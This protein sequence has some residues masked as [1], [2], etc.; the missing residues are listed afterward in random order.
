MCNLSK[1]VKDEGRREGMDIGL[2][3]GN[4]AS[5]KNLMKNLKLSLEQAM[6]TLEIPDADRAYYANAINGK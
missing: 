4:L 2:R 5:I 1:G 3:T 6:N